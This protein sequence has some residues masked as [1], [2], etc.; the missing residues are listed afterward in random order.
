[1]GNLVFTLGEL[2][3]PVNRN[4]EVMRYQREE[5]QQRGLTNLRIKPCRATIAD[6]AR[7]AFDSPAVRMDRVTRLQALIAA[8]GYWVSSEEIVL[9]LLGTMRRT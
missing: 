3:A 7:P 8:G 4:D 2:R 9:K 1:M 6:L 5:K